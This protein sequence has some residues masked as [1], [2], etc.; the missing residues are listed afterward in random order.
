[1]AWIDGNANGLWD[2][3]EQPLSWVQF[4]VKQAENVASAVSDGSG[5]AEVVLEY[6]CTDVREELGDQSTIEPYTPSG[7]HPIEPDIPP[8]FAALPLR[9]LAPEKPGSD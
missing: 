7:Y 9:F 8:G 3:D 5:E 4:Q 1:M 2:A 6:E